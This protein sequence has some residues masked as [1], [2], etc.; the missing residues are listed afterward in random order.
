MISLAR[1]LPR[2]EK[3]YRFIEQLAVHAENG[4]RHLQ[5]YVRSTDAQGREKAAAA[6]KQ[7]RLDAKAVSGEVTKELCLTFVTPFDREDIQDFCAGLYKITKTIEKI[8]DRM[9][10]AGL[11][12][13][14][15]DFARQIDLIVQEAAAMKDMVHALT[16]GGKSAQIL[17]KVAVLRDLENKGDAVLSDLLKS[18]FGEAR[19]PR[20]FILRKDI[21]DMLEKVIDRYRDAAGVALQIVL[22]HS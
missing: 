14:R 15:S 12:S 6:M 20:D 5:A 11:S 4:A 8:R 16:G 1:L 17:E 10:L 2:E 21:Y 22:K 7:C 18:L 9:E 3:F 19:D 13:D